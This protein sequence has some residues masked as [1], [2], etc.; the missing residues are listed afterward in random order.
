MRVIMLMDIKHL[1]RQVPFSLLYMD[2]LTLLSGVTV[3]IFQM[4]TLCLRES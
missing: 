4:R 2:H 3:P 1:L